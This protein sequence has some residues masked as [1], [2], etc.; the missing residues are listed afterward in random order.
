M[1]RL[2]LPGCKSEEQVLEKDIAIS[3]ANQNHKLGGA[4]KRMPPSGSREQAC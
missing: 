3:L 4:S 2:K 1:V